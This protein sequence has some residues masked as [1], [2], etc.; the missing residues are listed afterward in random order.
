M[1]AKIVAVLLAVVFFAGVVPVFA[2][3]APEGSAAFC[4]ECKTVFVKTPTGV[5]G[6]GFTSYT[7]VEK[8]TCPECESAVVNFFKT[9]D[10]KHACAI[11]GETMTE[12]HASE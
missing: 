9:G 7:T 12:C 2:E 5:P 11:C 8:M 4:S 1:K 10:F 3:E 6:K